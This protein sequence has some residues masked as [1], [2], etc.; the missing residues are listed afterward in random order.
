ME[1]ERLLKPRTDAFDRELERCGVMRPPP[2]GDSTSFFLG[3]VAIR[4]KAFVPELAKMDEAA[5]VDLRFFRVASACAFLVVAIFL[6]QEIVLRVAPGPSTT[7]EWLAAPV[8]AIERLRI[9]LM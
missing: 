1:H 9:S 6:F 7:D 3:K 5:S 2:P 8:A 4:T